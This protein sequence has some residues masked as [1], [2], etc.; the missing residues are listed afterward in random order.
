MEIFLK[1]LPPRCNEQRLKNVLRGPLKELGILAFDVNV[2]R[3]GGMG[4][5]TVAE[6]GFGQR[7]LNKY[8]SSA[9]PRMRNRIHNDAIRVSGKPVVFAPSRNTPDKHS[10]KALR[11][12]HRK[13]IQE[14]ERR[15]AP[16]AASQP[17]SNAREKKFDVQ[18]VEC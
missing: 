17:A 8:G 4:T 6:E 18:G 3:K 1:D 15:A 16:Q 10:I 7:S 12:S 5:L 14:E 9:N 11:E 2:L 13:I